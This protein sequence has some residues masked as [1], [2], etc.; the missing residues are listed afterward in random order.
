[1]LSAWLTAWPE[2]GDADRQRLGQVIERGWETQSQAFIT[3]AREAPHR[4]RW[5]APA[6]IRDSL[7]MRA[8][9]HSL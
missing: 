8:L 6:V 2:L 1:L 7:P 9:C 5:C 3:E 4:A